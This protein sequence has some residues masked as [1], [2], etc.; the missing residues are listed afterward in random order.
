M[1]W[2]IANLPLVGLRLLAHL[3][4]ALPAIAASLLLTIPVGSC[5]DR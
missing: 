1:S 5:C 2:L 3:A 4:Q